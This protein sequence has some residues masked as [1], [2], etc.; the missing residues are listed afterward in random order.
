[1]TYIIWMDIR[2][3]E[4]ALTSSDRCFIDFARSIGIYGVS[5]KMIGESEK[6]DRFYIRVNISNRKQELKLFNFFNEK[7]KFSFEQKQILN[8]LC[9]MG[10]V[11]KNDSR[12][13]FI[14]LLWL[15]KKISIS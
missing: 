8:H 11:A 1:M 14:I 12:L 4:K 9:D 2:K 6:A 7:R 5:E 15:F 10:S 3:Y 13:S